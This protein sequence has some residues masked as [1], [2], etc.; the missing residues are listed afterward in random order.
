MAVSPGVYDVNGC[1]TNATG[2][3]PSEPT[4]MPYGC[5]E[6]PLGVPIGNGVV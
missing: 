5:S 4:V 6:N 1:S 2:F 3:A